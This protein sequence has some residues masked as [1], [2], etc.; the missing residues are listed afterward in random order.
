MK[1]LIE[2]GADLDAQD[3]QGNSALHYAARTGFGAVVTMLVTA[4]ANK[5]L[6]N[7]LKQVPA[8]VALNNAIADLL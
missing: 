7:K 8:D 5:R 4:N 3:N 6:A 1:K 2:T